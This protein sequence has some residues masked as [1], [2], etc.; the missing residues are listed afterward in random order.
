MS[1]CATLRQLSAELEATKEA[2]AIVLDTKEA[3]LRSLVQQ[4]SDLTNE[5]LSFTCFLELYPMLSS[6][7][8]AKYLVPITVYLRPLS[9]CND[10]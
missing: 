7:L 9:C 8:L 10:S 6:L 1:V 3:V 5:V 4:M 2:H